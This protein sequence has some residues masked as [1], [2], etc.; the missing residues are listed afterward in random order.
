MLQISPQSLASIRRAVKSIDDD[1]KRLR[2]KI[3]E[4]IFDV[5]SRTRRFLKSLRHLKGKQSIDKICFRLT[6]KISLIHC[7]LSTV[8][9]Y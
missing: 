1:L 6:Q 8:G 3:D 9:R 4:P 5:D 2:A 7:F